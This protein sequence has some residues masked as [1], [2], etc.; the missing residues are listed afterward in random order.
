LRNKTF[1]NIKT[2]VTGIRKISET[3]AEVETK[4][5]INT[6]PRTI[7]EMSTGVERLRLRLAKE[8]SV[9]STTWLEGQSVSYVK[10][11]RRWRV[12]FRSGNVEEIYCNVPRH[13]DPNAS[14]WRDAGFRST[15]D[16]R[17]ASKN[18]IFSHTNTGSLLHKAL[19]KLTKTFQENPFKVQGKLSFQ[20]WDDGWR[21]IK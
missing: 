9:E 19:G 2:A 18:Q 20:L 8:A 21:V 12:T 11:Y 4:T 14:G 17:N 5:T 13:R 15:R 7:K 3:D 10:K 16:C 6:P 1:C